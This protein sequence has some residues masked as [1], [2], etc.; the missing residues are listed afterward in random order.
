VDS[1]ATTSR[2][3]RSRI[4]ALT[5]EATALAAAGDTA[6]VTIIA[7]TLEALAPFSG[8]GRDRRL[9]HHARGL[10]LEA[11]G[12]RDEALREFRQAIF[13]PT[14]GYTRTNLEMARIL[15]ELHRP[16]QA[17]AIL[18]S[19]LRGGLEASNMYVTHTDIHELLGRAFEV[20]GEP[21]S[22]ARYDQM[23]VDAWRNA[24]PAIAHR[25]EATGERLAGLAAPA[26]EPVR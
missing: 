26:P 17:I 5:Q 15:V 2:L 20:A 19:A 10:V 16:R 23:A 12:R 22:A 14:S 4:W 6:S 24:D 8:Y 3:A 21:D 18:Q 1:S 13:S 7:D 25:R 11:R 9:Y